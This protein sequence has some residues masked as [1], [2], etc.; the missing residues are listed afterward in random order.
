MGIKEDGM[1]N[2]VWE[3]FKL[4]FWMV[5]IGDMQF[6]QGKLKR[7]KKKKKMEAMTTLLNFA[8]IALSQFS[9]W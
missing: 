9:G 7:F 1:S 3:D 4:L 5:F 6:L 8:R 2:L